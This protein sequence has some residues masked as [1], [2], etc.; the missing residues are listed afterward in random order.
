M[1]IKAFLSEPEV[2][3]TFNFDGRMYSMVMGLGDDEMLAFRELQKNR[4]FTS[5]SHLSYEESIGVDDSHWG[6]A[7]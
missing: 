6:Y 3:L 5:D 2:V 4:G 1:S 7:S